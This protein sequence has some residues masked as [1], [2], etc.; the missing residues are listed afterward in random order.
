MPNRTD[1]GAGATNGPF[2]RYLAEHGTAVLGYLRSS[3]GP[4]EADDVFQ[5]AFIAALRAWEPGARAP[6][7]AWIFRIAHNKAIDHHRAAGRRPLSFAEPPEP[8]HTDADRLEAADLRAQVAGLPEGQRAAVGLR[9]FADLAYRDVGDALEISE[10]A[11]RRR[12]A[13]GLSALRGQ[14]EKEDV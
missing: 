4:G 8:A 3:V 10:Q 5:E 1:A 13:D 11:A 2:S 12:V 9:F 6:G 14:L 7:R